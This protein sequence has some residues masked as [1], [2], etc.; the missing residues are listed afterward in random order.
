MAPT[1]GGPDGVYR[2]L[3]ARIL[4]H[5]L[6]PGARIAIGREAERL[7]VSQTPVREALSRLE[8]DR[9]VVRAASRGYEVTS[10]IGVADLAH[11]YEVRLL[12]EPW[13]S[14]Q[15]AADR[16]TN[17]IAALRR[18]LDR[19]EDARAAGGDLRIALA[20]HDSRFHGAVVR[21]AGNG[22]LT[23]T[24][25]QLHAHVHLFRLYR[26]DLGG[27][28]TIHEHHAIADA[29]ERC[30]GPSAEEAMRAHLRNAF[31]RFSAAF[32][33]PASAGPRDARSRV[34]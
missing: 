6:E 18:E 10:L 8:G 21:A 29:V 15:A 19:F 2:A 31:G 16:L 9:L 1:A 27:T 28:A 14:R 34:R 4:A 25:E 22:L 33:D 26:D 5:D 23:E 11:L 24:Y 20:D 17:P 3:R 7:G 12:L 13:A 30:D 32:A